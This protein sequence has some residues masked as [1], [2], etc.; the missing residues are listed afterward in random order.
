MR[1]VH[2]IAT[3]AAEEG[4]PSRAVLDMAMAMA[5]RG[6]E[7]SIQTT[8][9]GDAPVDVTAATGLG[10]KIDIHPVGVPRRWKRSTALRAALERDLPKADVV[11]LHSL[12]L[13]HCLVTE[14]ICRQARVPYILRP[15]GTLDP[16]LQQRH[17]S[18]KALVGALFQN[19]VTDNAAGL[20]FTAQEEQTLARPYAR[21]QKGFV[22]PLP[23]DPAEFA[24][25]PPATRFAELY[26]ETAG[27][28]VVLFMSRLNFKKGLDLLVEAFGRVAAEQPDLHLV[29]AGPDDG[30]RAAVETWVSEAGLDQRVTLPGM[31]RGEARLA[32]LAAAELS[33]LPSYSE[34]FGYAVVE[35][36]ACGLPVLISNNVNIWREV[37][38]A[39][40]GLVCEASVDALTQSLRQ[41]LHD[42]TQ[43]QDRGAKG[44]ALVERL[45]SPA[46]VGAQLE[47]MY[48]AVRS[49][50]QG[51]PG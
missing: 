38:A 46:A 49:K 22:V 21:G 31:L 13:Y 23:L 16:F 26:P 11:H 7:V 9:Y 5:Q 27:R 3:L 40:A 2:V 50:R 48:E 45:F 44:K 29:I 39:D 4:G 12:Y 41:S 30:M 18:R 15:H 34:N 20:H 19:R 32:A 24:A 36:M 43:N 10:V 35:A 25:L 42:A 14:Q 8:D 17:R 51:P 33:V 28:R 37:Q 1:I 6:H 47:E